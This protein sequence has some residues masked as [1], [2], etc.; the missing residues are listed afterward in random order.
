LRHPLI[1][2]LY[3]RPGSKYKYFNV[4]NWWNLQ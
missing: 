4:I 1:S 3:L 2:T